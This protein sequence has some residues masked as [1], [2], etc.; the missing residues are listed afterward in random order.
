MISKLQWKFRSW[1]MQLS[2]PPKLTRGMIMSLSQRN[3]NRAQVNC[4]CKDIYTLVSA[5]DQMHRVV[6]FLR[7]IF[8]L[9]KYYSSSMCYCSNMKNWIRCLRNNLIEIITPLIGSCNSLKS[10]LNQN[11]LV[12]ALARKRNR[13]IFR[14]CARL[15]T[16]DCLACREKH[17]NHLYT[18][19][20]SEPLPN[21]NRNRIVGLRVLE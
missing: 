18:F 6:M 5:I 12:V 7:K 20:Q 8:P 17:H 9:I 19:D 1:I 4:F 2:S 13:T 3:Q 16:I 21:V 11:N 10:M 15:G 14:L